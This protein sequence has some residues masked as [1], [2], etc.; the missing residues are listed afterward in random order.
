MNLMKYLTH[1]RAVRRTPREGKTCAEWE[2]LPFMVW[3]GMEWEKDTFMK[4]EKMDRKRSNMNTIF[5]LSF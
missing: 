1:Q 5:S 4:G 3:R 2:K